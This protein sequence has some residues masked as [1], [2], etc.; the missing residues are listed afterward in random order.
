M[1]R[2]YFQKSRLLVTIIALATIATTV[3]GAYDCAEI[4]VEGNTYNIAALKPMYVLFC[5]AI[6]AAY[7][8]QYD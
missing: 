8:L 3:A 4:R 6:T 7:P 5:L 2:S 1:T